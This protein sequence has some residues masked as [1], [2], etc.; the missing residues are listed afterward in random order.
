[1]AAGAPSV[2]PAAVVYAPGTLGIPKTALA[3]YRNAEHQMAA[4]APEVGRE[5]C[6]LVSGASTIGEAMTSST[7]RSSRKTALGFFEAWRRALTAI[8][9]KLSGALRVTLLS[10]S[11]ACLVLH[12]V[13]V[14]L[15]RLVFR[16]GAMDDDG[17]LRMAEILPYY[18][19]GVPTFGVLLVLVRAHIA[20]QNSRVMVRMGILN[21][22]VNLAGNAILAKV[23]GLKGIALSTSVVHAIVAA[24]LYV[25]MNKK[26]RE[27]EA[28]ATTS[29]VVP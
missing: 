7:V 25:M 27:L 6:T 10:L 13:R 24:V 19:A 9:A 14:P 16:H 2:P 17:V 1:M 22:A 23:M 5:H 26:L 8:R 29:E 18:L 4:A 28:A 12:L 20:A 11:A 21:A 3:A 15:L